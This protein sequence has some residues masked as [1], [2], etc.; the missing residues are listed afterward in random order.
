MASRLEGVSI[1]FEA[2]SIAS[3]KLVSEARRGGRDLGLWR[4]LWLWSQTKHRR[5]LCTL[6]A[7]LGP[8][9]ESSSGSSQSGYS[10]FLPGPGKGGGRAAA[11][12]AEDAPAV[13][14]SKEES[15]RGLL[16]QEQRL[17]KVWS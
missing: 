7:G 8:L 9:A 15:Q 5:H 4:P 6:W 17:T 13:P 16:G 10:K 12:E 1:P 3:S 14:Q 2:A 11:L